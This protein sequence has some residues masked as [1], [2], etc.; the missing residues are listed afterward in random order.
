M[1]YEKTKPTISAND[2][3][4]SALHETK[5]HLHYGLSHKLTRNG[6]SGE[7]IF[8]IGEV[9]VVVV[10]GRGGEESGCC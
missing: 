8:S 1:P 5:D 6:E 9:E 4:R 2:R 10:G 7:S 3:T